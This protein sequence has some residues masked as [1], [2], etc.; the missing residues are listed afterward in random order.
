M[1]LADWRTASGQM[2]MLSCPVRE[3][4]TAGLLL[5]LACKYCGDQS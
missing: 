2:G 5:M 3:Q 4:V 1:V